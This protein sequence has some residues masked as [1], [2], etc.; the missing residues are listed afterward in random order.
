[1]NTAQI[2][3]IYFKIITDSYFCDKIFS[4]FP[5]PAITI[6]FYK[7]KSIDE[8]NYFYFDDKFKVLRISNYYDISI[9]LI[10]DMEVS[11]YKSNEVEFLQIIN[12]DEILINKDKYIP[13]FK[14]YEDNEH[15]YNELIDILIT[16]N[17]GN[18]VSWDHIWDD[19]ENTI[20]LA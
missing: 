10:N 14:S 8:F 6:E 20:A 2:K 7:V 18:N 12:I 9:E 3:A 16:D 11:N 19:Y 1:M 5:N 15:C 4:R 17:E 13:I